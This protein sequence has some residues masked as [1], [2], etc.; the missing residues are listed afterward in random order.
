MQMAD[1][2]S[3]WFGTARE[4]VSSVM[5]R[6]RKKLVLVVE[7]DGESL[8]L[9]GKLLNRFNRHCEVHHTGDGEEAFASVCARPPDLIIASPKLFGINGFRFVDNIKMDFHA[10][11]IP[12]VLTTGLTRTALVT[13]LL[14]DLA[15]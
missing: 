11:K 8:N 10:S 9:I 7:R 2:I 5:L 12:L 13:Y 1:R 6:R 15:G 4:I 3:G 14:T